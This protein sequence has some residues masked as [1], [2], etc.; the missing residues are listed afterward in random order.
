MQDYEVINNLLNV[1]IASSKVESIKLPNK[2]IRGNIH[3]IIFGEPGIGKSTIL[4]EISKIVKSSIMRKFTS[5]NLLGA[6]DKNTGIFIP[7]I[8]WDSKNNVL[9]IDEFNPSTNNYKEDVLETLLTLMEFAEIKKSVGYR[10]NDYNKKD[11]DLYCKVKNGKIEMKTRFS[12]FCTSMRHPSALSSV[13]SKALKSRC[14]ILHLK[15]TIEELKHEIYYDSY[16]FKYKKIK[17]DKK[18]FVMKKKDIDYITNYIQNTQFKIGTSFYTRTVGDFC[19]IFCIL[20]KH[21]NDIYDYILR[22]RTE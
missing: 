6:V 20:K 15:K 19:R 10:C 11:G 9:M 4:S 22:S 21:D 1:G 14:I 2:I 18:N 16:S 3:L 7:P 17:V 8:T 12:F 13:Y 5:A